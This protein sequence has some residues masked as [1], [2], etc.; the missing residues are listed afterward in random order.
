MINNINISFIIKNLIFI[1]GIFIFKND[2][3]GKI[4]SVNVKIRF[5]LFGICLD[6]LLSFP[7]YQYIFQYSFKTHVL[8]S[9]FY[10]FF[11]LRIRFLIRR[12]VIRVK[13]GRCAQIG[14]GDKGVILR[15]RSDLRIPVG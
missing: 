12:S 1:K 8:L 5:Q 4:S 11:Y 2:S 7:L 9:F 14:E 6:V 15:E 13:T 10:F 3:G